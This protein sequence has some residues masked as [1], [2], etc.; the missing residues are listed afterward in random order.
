MKHSIFVQNENGD[1]VE[2]R[3]SGFESED[4]FQELLEKYP[5]L[6]AGDQID[7]NNPRKWL[8][9]S[10]EM[11]VPTKEDGGNQWSLDHLFID[12][13]AIPTF[14]EV[15]RSTDTRIRREVVG[16][17]LD[18]AANGIKYW[19]INQIKEKYELSG[20][21][22]LADIGIEPGSEELFWSNVEANLKSGKLRL[23]FVA[24][25]IPET[26]KSIIEFLNNQMVNTEVLGIEIKQFVSEG[27]QK[28]LVPRVIGKTAEATN[29]KISREGKQWDEDLFM[30]EVRQRHGDEA[31]TVYKNLLDAFQ[32][33]GIRIYWGIGKQLGS[34]VPIYDGKDGKTKH[35]LFAAYTDGNIEIYF[36]H[37]KIPYETHEARMQLREKFMKISG[38]QIDERRLT[39]RPS[40]KWSALKNEVDLN[41]FVEIFDEFLVSVRAVE[42]ENN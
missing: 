2:M 23:L 12:Q 1:L 35:Q 29:L 39:G 40:F 14:V 16:Q 19:G 38:I 15:K 41:K 9:I 24:D 37:Y 36:Q 7:E 28:T 5:Q 26:L 18:Y 3:E 27:K 6:L 17:M 32:N 42:N 11:G 20:K 8:F 34:F 31:R 10:R 33:R 4:I 25:E 21:P 30:E 13:D 22:S